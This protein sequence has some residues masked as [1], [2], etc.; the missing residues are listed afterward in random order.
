LESQSGLGTEKDDKSFQIWV[1]EIEVSK[2]IFF[3]Y[4]DNDYCRLDLKGVNTANSI[5]SHAT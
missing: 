1:R 3:V 4:P 5:F 2:K